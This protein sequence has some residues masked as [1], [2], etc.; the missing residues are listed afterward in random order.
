MS[1]RRR[2]GR[3]DPGTH[4]GRPRA[5]QERAP[6]ARH[7]RA[8]LE[9]DPGRGVR[10]SLRW[11]LHR[12]QRPDA[13]CPGRRSGL[14]SG[15]PALRRTERERVSPASVLLQG[16]SGSPRGSPRSSQ[17]SAARTWCG[18]APGSGTPRASSRWA[19][20]TASLTARKSTQ[21]GS[22]SRRRLPSSPRSRSASP[23]R[24]TS[25]KPWPGSDLLLR[26]DARAPR[27]RLARARARGAL[28]EV[29]ALLPGHSSAWPGG[30]NGTAVRSWVRPP[31]LARRARARQGRARPAGRSPPRSPGRRGAPRRAPAGAAR[32]R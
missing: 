16:V 5:R 11:L 23:G 30:L 31:R 15:R 8:P 25:V 2:R 3:K 6:G 19:T 13:A 7:G 22:P 26:A 20:R 28:G 4:Q 32:S 1:R 14:R 29:R 18:T 21:L 17:R 12:E 24:V 27:A 10:R 9:R